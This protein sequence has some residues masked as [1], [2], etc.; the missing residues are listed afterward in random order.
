MSNELST[1]VE[2]FMQQN[3]VKP[4]Q[5]ADAPAPTT[6]LEKNLLVGVPAFNGHVHTSA[7]NLLLDLAKVLPFPH[8][9]FFLAGESLIS[10]G[11]NLISSVATFGQDGAGRK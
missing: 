7:V 3:G 10:R 2:K 11:R 9:V 8:T 5:K 4:D 1:A 6:G